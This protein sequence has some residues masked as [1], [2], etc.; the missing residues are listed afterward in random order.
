MATLIIF[1]HG[2]GSEQKTWDNFINVLK[3]DEK[4]K[5]VKEYKIGISNDFSSNE[6]YYYLYNYESSL[7]NIPII[8]KLINNLSESIS[9]NKNKGSISINNHMESLKSFIENNKDF[10]HIHIVSHSLGGIITLKLLVSLID[11]K[12]KLSNKIKKVILY[13]S[14]IKGS[15][16]PKKLGMSSTSILKELLPTSITITGLLQSLSIY[17]EKLKESFKIL[18][19]AGDKDSRIIDITENDIKSFSKYNRVQGGHSDIINP[20][21]I[22]SQSFQIFKT[23]IFEDSLTYKKDLFYNYREILKKKISE[24]NSIVSPERKFCL[25]EL[26]EPISLKLTSD[27]SLN[28][29]KNDNN[30][31][32]AE[33]LDNV[34]IEFGKNYF[35]IDEAGMGKS[36]FSK[37]LILRILENSN[38]IPILLELFEY[39]KSIP[40][41][42]NLLSKLDE[43]DNKFNKDLFNKLIKEGE[44]IFILDGFDELTLDLQNQLKNEI[45]RLD[46]KKVKSS[47]LITSRPQEI[48]PELI[49][50]ETYKLIKLSK[51]QASNILLKYDNILSL[52]VGYKLINELDKVPKRFFETPLLVGLLY[53]TYGFNHSIAEKI[54]VFYAEIYDALFKGH[55]LTKSGFRREKRSNLDIDSF[56]RLLRSLSFLYILHDSNKITS[57]ESFLNLIDEA[58]KL[59]SSEKINSRNFLEDLLC[60]VPLLVKDGKTIKFIHRTI[61]EYFAAEY[62]VQSNFSTKLIEG[63]IQNNNISKFSKVLEFIYEIAPNLYKEIITLPIA[64]NF[65]DNYNENYSDIYLTSIFLVNNDISIWKKDEIMINGKIRGHRINKS[66]VMNR[67]RASYQYGKYQNIDYVIVITTYEEKIIPKN[68]LSDIGKSTEYS[69]GRYSKISDDSIK[70]LLENLKLNTFYDVNSEEIRKISSSPVIQE[71]LSRALIMAIYQQNDS[72]YILNKTSCVEFIKKIETT[73]EADK[74]LFSLIL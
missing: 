53:R 6:I 9:G 51:E 74:K 11:N 44:F 1:I 68:V 69:R 36:T 66:R 35:I 19:I 27:N 57:E 15:N 14:P 72:L 67:N 65:I 48:F 20:K 39:D 18:Y 22:S 50:S 29:F 10:N 58:Q 16:E 8:G 13:G 59:Q 5:N 70:F 21:N 71:A 55:D 37:S 31:D 63:F 49:K 3:N 34:Y 40:L 33:F 38:R 30:F 52:N 61:A 28:Y 41:Y 54:S 45:K 73:I 25:K 62:I 56:K 23:H 7:I 32:K 46:E 43:I 4:T 12:D 64:K 26:Y 47:M 42:E 2:V 60:A 17:S 24:V